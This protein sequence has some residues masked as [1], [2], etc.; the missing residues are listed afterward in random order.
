MASEQKLTSSDFRRNA[1]LY[2]IGAVIAFMVMI[3]GFI[4]DSPEAMILGALACVCSA[5][6]SLGNHFNMRVKR[7]DES[8][9]TS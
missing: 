3:G 2:G 1:L 4:I 9:S 7:L 5:M 8:S 6:L